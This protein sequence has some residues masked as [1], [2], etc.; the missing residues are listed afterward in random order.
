[1]GSHLGMTEGL[2]FPGGDG[3]FIQTSV[4]LR[5]RIKREKVLSVRKLGNAGL[6]ISRGFIS[7][8]TTAVPQEQ[9]AVFAV[10][11]PNYRNIEPQKGVTAPSIDAFRK[12]LHKE[13][14]W[15]QSFSTD[16]SHE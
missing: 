4:P 13:S 11:H 15:N 1:M 10:R 5:L 3:L 7:T 14:V 8:V 9:K 2:T 16:M 12:L 6:E